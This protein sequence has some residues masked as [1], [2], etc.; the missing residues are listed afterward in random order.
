M[1]N[2]WALNLSRFLLEAI[3]SESGRR[4][5]SIDPQIES[6]DTDAGCNADELGCLRRWQTGKAFLTR[7][8]AE[9]QQKD[10]TGRDDEEFLSE[11]ASLSGED[12]SSSSTDRLIFEFLLLKYYISPSKVNVG[13]FLALS[14]LTVDHG[15][16]LRSRSGFESQTPVD[17]PLKILP[18]HRF[19]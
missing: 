1:P 13:P 16:D 12:R 5:K 3:V 15:P 9:S 17:P 2:D 19:P 11:I 7:L 8:L 14:E 6:R 18:S 10:A 4:A